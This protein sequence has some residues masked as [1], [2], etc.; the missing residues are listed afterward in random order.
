V[1][2]DVADPYRDK[3]NDVWLVQEGIFESTYELLPK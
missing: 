3:A 1:K 2:D